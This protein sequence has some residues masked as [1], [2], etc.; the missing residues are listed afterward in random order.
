MRYGAFVN[1]DGLMI[2]DGN[3]YKHADERFWVHDQ[4]RG[5]R[6]LVPRD[7]RRPR[8]RGSR[9]RTEEL[10]DDRGPGPDVAGDGAG[11]HGPRPVDLGT[12]ASGPSRRPWP[13]VQAT[14]LRTGFSGEHGYEVVVAARDRAG[15][16]GRADRGRRRSRSGSRR[17]T[18]RAPRS[19]LIII[20]RRLQPGRDLALGPVDGPVHQ[21]GD[22]E[23]RRRGA[24]GV[25]RPTRRSASRRCRSRGTPCRRHGCGRDEGRRRGRLG[26]VAGR[27]RPRSARSR[28]RSWTRMSRTTARRSRSAATPSRPWRRSACSTRRRSGRESDR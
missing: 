24:G 14:V 20:A 28:S 17:S 27:S 15:V 10:R 25:R 12:S 1:A 2:D 11:A 9:H 19:G 8:C 22:R 4:H 18:S 5:H 13:G 16:V 6:G 23:R 3:V 21:D 7:G 26:D